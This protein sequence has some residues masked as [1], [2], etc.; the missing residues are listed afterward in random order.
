M[1]PFVK[2]G[3]NVIMWNGNHIGHHSVIKDHCFIA[4]HVVVS[5]FCEIGE[6]CFLGVNSTVANNVKV[7]SNCLIGAGAVILKDTEEGKVYGSK[8]TKPKSYSSFAYYGLED[9]EK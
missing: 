2:V 5:G 4:S 9:R 8:M 7:A 3:N 1:Q 6:Y